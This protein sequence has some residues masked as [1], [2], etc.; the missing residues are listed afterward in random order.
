V[1]RSAGSFSINSGLIKVTENVSLLLI[2]VGECCIKG[3]YYVSCVGCDCDVF[4]YALELLKLVNLSKCITQCVP[5]FNE[6]FR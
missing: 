5:I 3:K 6:K 4:T 1:I 2:H